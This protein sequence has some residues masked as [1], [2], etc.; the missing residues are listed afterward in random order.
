MQAFLEQCQKAHPS[1]N[2]CAT[3]Q[4]EQPTLLDASLSQRLTMSSLQRAHSCAQ[5]QTNRL[6]EDWL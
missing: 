4:V 5:Q 3:I 6:V 1:D 2:S